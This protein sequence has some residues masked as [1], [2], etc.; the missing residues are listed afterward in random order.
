MLDHS[1]GTSLYI[2]SSNI[3]KIVYIFYV[4]TQCITSYQ[5]FIVKNR[6]KLTSVC[7][8]YVNVMDLLKK[9]AYSWAGGSVQILLPLN[10]F[11]T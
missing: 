10:D 8:T 7:K 11:K 4:D 2:F 9:I 3:P 1:R 5:F 6:G